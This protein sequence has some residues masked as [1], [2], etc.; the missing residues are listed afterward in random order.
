MSAAILHVWWATTLAGMAPEDP[1]RL[2][3]PSWWQDVLLVTLV[4]AG[5]VVILLLVLLAI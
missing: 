2:S 4:C 5:V 3:E 1:H